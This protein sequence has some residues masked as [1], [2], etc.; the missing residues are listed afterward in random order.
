[1]E[2]FSG[3]S[4]FVVYES[5][6]GRQVSYAEAIRRGLSRYGS[7]FL[8]AVVTSLLFY[9]GFLALLVPG[10]IIGA[11]YFVC[12][13]VCMLQGVGV[14][15]SLSRSNE[16]TRGYKGK[17]AIVMIVQLAAVFSLLYFGHDR[18]EIEFAF[19]VLTT[20]Y[21]IPGTCEWPARASR[22]G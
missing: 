4:I 12:D 13:Q 20:A 1:V 6:N 7:M 8:L 18:P 2:A 14:F 21:L 9:A 5:L 3:I 11:A 17:L 10:V 19:N 15:A 16:L 22:D